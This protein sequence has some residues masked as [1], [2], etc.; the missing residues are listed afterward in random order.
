MNILVTIA[1]WTTLVTCY[2]VYDHKDDLIADGAIIA[3]YNCDP[4]A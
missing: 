4:N 2:L 1:Y 3:M